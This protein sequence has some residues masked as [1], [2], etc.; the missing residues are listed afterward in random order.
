MVIVVRN[1]FTFNHWMGSLAVFVGGVLYVLG[2]K[3]KKD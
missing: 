3:P 1:P 2:P